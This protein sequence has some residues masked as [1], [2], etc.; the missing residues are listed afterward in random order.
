MDADKLKSLLQEIGLGDKLR[1]VSNNSDTNFMFKC[2]WHGERNPSAGISAE[3]EYGACFTCGQGFTLT[4]LVATMKGCSLIKAKDFLEEKFNVSKKVL[5]KNPTMKRYDEESINP[6]SRVILPRFNLAPYRSGKVC[7]SYLL[8]RGFTKETCKKF[9]LGWDE[10]KNR[11][12]IPVFWQD[13]EL[14]GFVGR[15]VLEPKINGKDNPQ[16]K[17]IYGDSDKY[18]MYEFQRSHL[19]FPL[20]KFILPT[21]KTAILVEGSLDSPWMHQLGFTNT[22][23]TL[24]SSISEEQVSLLSKLGVKNVILMLD[25]DEAGNKGMTKAYSMMKKDFNLFKVS[26]P[27]G[28]KDPQNLNEKQVQRMLDNKKPFNFVQL[29]RLT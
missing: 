13:G 22:L 4:F 24:T 21:D 9:M 16:Y 6:I 26:Y 15:A 18:L 2:P 27:E 1:T 11:I 3:K 14:A 20:D 28:A 29:K 12:T 25:A 5:T 17:K 19:L 23:S 8:D 10:T 7:H